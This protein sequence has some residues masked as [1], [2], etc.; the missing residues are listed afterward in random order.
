M[1]IMKNATRKRKIYMRVTQDKY[2][3]ILDWDTNASRLARRQGL[4]A[5]AIHEYLSQ[6]KGGR[7]KTEYPCWEVVEIEEDE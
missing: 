5:H 7:L 3:L 4:S 6:V 2:S 1:R